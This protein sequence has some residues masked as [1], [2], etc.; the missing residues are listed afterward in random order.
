MIRLVKLHLG[1]GDIN[2]GFPSVRIEIFDNNNSLLMTLKGS[3]P[4]VTEVIELYN[5]WQQYYN[6]FCSC[7]REDKNEELEIELVDGVN[8]FSRIDFDFLS[9]ELRREINKWFDFEYFQNIERELRTKLDSTEQI[10]FLIEIDEILL[11]RIPWHLW[12][13]FDSYP[14][15]EI[16]LST[17]ESQKIPSQI[18]RKK[19]RIL[20]ILGDDTGI[21]IQKDKEHLEK[22]LMDVDFC[23]LDKDNKL[24]RA[25]LFEHLSDSKGWDILFFAGHS[26]N[27]NIKINSEEI[28]TIKELRNALKKSLTNGLKLA[29]FNSCDGLILGENLLDLNF[30]QV[31]VMREPISDN[32]AHEFLKNFLSEFYAGKSLYLSVREAREKL[33]GLE[34]KSPYASWLPVIFK[35]PTE[36]ILTWQKLPGVIEQQQ[37]EFKKQQEEFKKQQEKIKRKK[38]ILGVGGVVLTIFMGILGYKAISKPALIGDHLSIGEEILDETFIPYPKKKAVELVA[39]C[40]QPSINY[41]NILDEQTRKKWQGCIFTKSNYEEAV[42]LFKESWNVNKDPETLIYLNNALL[43]AKGQKAYTIAVVIPILRNEDSSFKNANLAQTLLRGIAQYQTEI[44]LGLFDA[45][46]PL[47]KD[48]PGKDLSNITKGGVKNGIGLKVIIA[49]DA[50]KTNQTEYIAQKLSRQP[51]V[52]GVVGS[53]ASDMSVKSVPIYAKNKLVLISS[54]TTTT[55]F[56]EKPSDFFF[57]VVNNNKDYAK[58]QSQYLIDKKYKK[59]AIF[60]NPQSP[61]SYNLWRDFQEIFINGEIV[62]NGDLSNSE[63]D[64]EKII[65]DIDKIDKS[66]ETVLMLIAD[67][68][69]TNSFDRAIELVKENNG[70]RLIISSWSLHRPQTLALEKIELFEK[71]VMISPL[72]LSSATDFIDHSDQK[73]WDQTQTWDQTTDAI[74]VLTYD[75][76]LT[77]I[78][79]FRQQENP[80][81]E[82]T[83][84]ILADDDF[85]AEGATGE[86]KF[87][88]QNGDRQDPKLG[89]LGIRKS[90]NP[91]SKYDLEFVGKKAYQIKGSCGDNPTLIEINK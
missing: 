85:K 39:E 14:N 11:K 35:N 4:S 27:G 45:D 50:N 59:I 79:A 31:I 12:S 8:R 60:Y 80:T 64:H 66:N 1:S 47:L 16:V 25:N 68:Q 10:I 36:N 52:L 28:L 19:P 18:N 83:Q 15:A 73:L 29:I 57:R 37:E 42:K 61:F 90:V 48:F 56:T 81:R 51:D 70:K 53:Y 30:P 7:N 23:F 3:L 72:N 22:I 75:A 41:L 38:L 20:V 63:F 55:E 87:C 40:H 65:Q 32:V 69:V 89:L 13:F 84:K 33:Q 34:D 91:N 78:E 5:E 9:E 58:I 67:G 74:T 17:S 76:T 82:G 49:D 54:G 88:P 2:R 21:D 62:M 24:S 43:E 44:N 26:S 77:L 71:F 46:D 6:V 86:I